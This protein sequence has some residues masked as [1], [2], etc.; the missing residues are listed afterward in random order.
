MRIVLLIAAALAV[1]SCVPKA[2]VVPEP[3]GP[4]V[5]AGRWDYPDWR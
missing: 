3:A 2:I 5:E 1:T 4:I